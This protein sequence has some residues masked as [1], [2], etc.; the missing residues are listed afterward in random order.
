VN[1]PAQAIREGI[2][3]VPEDRKGQGLNLGQ[4]GAKN[5]VSPWERILCKSGFVTK[6]WV[7]NLA[8]STAKAFDVRGG[9]SQ[10]VERLSGGNQQKVMLAKWLVKEP[11]VLILDEPTRGVDVGAKMA[12]YQIIRDVASRGVAVV[13]VSSELEEILGISNRV[14]VMSGGKQRQILDRTEANAES[15]MSLAMPIGAK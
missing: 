4:S 15:V 6:G 1:S 9:I 14:L 5:I 11:K 10:S 12:I 7:K 2:V 13:V 3:M 8:E